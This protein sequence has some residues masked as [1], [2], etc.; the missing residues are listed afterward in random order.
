VT[1]LRVQFVHR[2]LDVVGGAEV[3]LADQARFLSQS[4][5]E[6]RVRTLVLDPDTWT[7]K[8]TGVPVDAWHTCRTGAERPRLTRTLGRKHLG[9][10]LADLEHSDAAIAM[11]FPLSAALGRERSRAIRVW[12][13][14]EPPRWLHPE[15]ANPYLAKN[16]TR[17]PDRHAPHRYRTSLAS[18]VG[19]LPFFGRRRP[20]RREADRQGVAGLD[21]L[22]ALSEYTRD[23]VRRIYRGRDADVLSPMV[24]FPERPSRHFGVRRD[25]LRVLC[26]TRLMWEKNLDTLVEGFARYRKKDPRATLDFVG[27]GPAL[28][29]LKELAASLGIAPALR[30]HGFLSEEELGRL[31][32]QSDVFACLPID[33]PFGLIFPEA[34]ARGLLVLGPDHGGP[35]EILDHGRYGEL[36]DPL[37]PEAIA[38]GLS[39]LASLSDDAAEK[40]RSEADAACRDRYSPHVVGAKM[41]SLLARH[42]LS[43][44]NGASR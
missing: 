22:W 2:S 13:C 23:S 33:E 5:V 10:L 39:R 28:E 6:P 36:A 24:T 15:E 1:A 4:G 40:R 17:A 42:G 41:L 43:V 35:V 29:P 31:A 32:G 7:P 8:L 14:L 27:T 16:A 19:A 11:S 26:V 9:W 34:I 18:P 3:L 20:S 21:A 37:D 38:E 44:P 12:Y 30:F 25:G